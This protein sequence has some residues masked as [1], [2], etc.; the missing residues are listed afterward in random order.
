MIHNSLAFQQ[1]LSTPFLAIA[2]KYVGRLAIEKLSEGPLPL[3]A[4][5]IDLFQKYA[6]APDANARFDINR[7]AWRLLLPNNLWFSNLQDEDGLNDDLDLAD[8]NFQFGSSFHVPLFIQAF[9]DGF[10]ISNFEATSYKYDSERIDI[11]YGDFQPVSDGPTCP[12]LNGEA[13]IDEDDLLGPEDVSVSS[14]DGET[15][16]PKGHEKLIPVYETMKY[17]P[18]GSGYRRCPGESFNYFF[19]DKLLSNFGTLD[20]KFVGGNPDI[21]EL[22]GGVPCDVGVPGGLACRNDNIFLD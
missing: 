20:F 17:C 7:E 19:M 18:F 16:I 13:S 10:D 21:A 12:F 1:F 15:M 8:E 5:K 4:T 11:R 3:E 9:N 2:A 6:D 22:I 14:I